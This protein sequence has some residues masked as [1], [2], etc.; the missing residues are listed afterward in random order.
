MR[1]I[2]QDACRAV[3]VVAVVVVGRPAGA[4]GLIVQGEGAVNVGFTQTT[5]SAAVI[6]PTAQASDQP[7]SSASSF[8]TEL[9][10][11]IL[12]QFGSPRLTWRVNYAFSAALSPDSSTSVAYSNQANLSAAAE[13][14]KFS[15]MTVSGSAAQ[16]GTSF[17][18]S[19]QPAEA[20]KPAIRAPG[21]PDLVSASATEA[22]SWQV[23]QIFVVQQTLIGSLSAPENDL[24][25]RSSE[26]TGTLAIEHQWGRDA[27]GLEGRASVA[28]L[29]PQQADIPPYKTT[30]NDL[31]G[32][33]NHDFT[34]QW[35][36]FARVGIE[37]L[38]MGTGNRP[39]ALLPTGNAI[40]RYSAGRLVTGVDFTH[41]S[42]TNLQVGSVSLT[43]Q[44]TGH[45]I[46]T[47][48][49]QKARVLSFSAGFLHNEPI[50]EARIAAGTGNAVQGDVGFTTM[51]TKH[52]VLTARYSLAYQFGQDGGVGS[53]L[54]HTVLVGVIARYSNTSKVI[55]P[56][57]TRGDRVDGSDG[58]GFLPSDP[59]RVPDDAEK[60]R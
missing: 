9:R 18:L 47:I 55:R 10:P 35:N 20:G 58:Q 38:Y 23:S 13:L 56:V 21:N 3:V 29:R 24:H 15:M 37:Q 50:G 5:Q 32:R 39:L 8:L 54:I 4:Q 60:T 41:G 36:A 45:G 28:W 31:L 6:D 53:T 22:L 44:A 27:V 48:D 46:F 25:D 11:G 57:P 40:V 26:L 1:D 49:P 30:T 2:V 16:G 51:L 59:S 34:P 12:L 14:T 17:L 52:S 33:W 7:V 19:Q 43:D 42:A